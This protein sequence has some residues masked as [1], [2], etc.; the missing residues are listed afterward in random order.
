[1]S[2][3]ATAVSLATTTAAAA[4]G[5]ALRGPSAR[6]TD[7]L[8]A[9]AAAPDSWA[10]SGSRVWVAPADGVGT[11]VSPAPECRVV[12]RRLSGGRGARGAVINAPYPRLLDQSIDN[13]VVC[14]VSIRQ[15]TVTERRRAQR[16]RP[17]Q[18]QIPH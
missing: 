5:T 18:C 8:S 14:E 7:T 17:V 16:Q 6:P 11:E 1:M 3:A 2:A 15:T 12:P 10:S 9:A 13:A 4:T